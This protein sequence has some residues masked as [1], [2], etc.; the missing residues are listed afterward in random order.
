[1]NNVV[2]V[3]AIQVTEK[4]DLRFWRDCVKQE[5]INEV[6]IT[7]GVFKGTRVPLGD[8]IVRDKEGNVFPMY[9]DYFYHE[10]CEQHDNNSI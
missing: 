9:A 1:M 10:F 7:E 4:A 5:N 2:F 3:N 6:V 8:F